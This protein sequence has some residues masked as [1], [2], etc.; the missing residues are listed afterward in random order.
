MNEY[1]CV[2]VSPYRIGMNDDKKERCP[3]TSEHLN[4]LFFV[5]LIQSD[6]A[7]ISPVEQESFLHDVRVCHPRSLL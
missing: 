6:K 1:G 7:M 5:C 4:C 3:E 2:L